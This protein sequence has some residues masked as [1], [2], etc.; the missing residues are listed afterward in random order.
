MHHVCVCVPVVA[1]TWLCR[2]LGLSPGYCFN[3]MH[4]T[5]GLFHRSEPPLLVQLLALLLIIVQ[6]G[7]EWAVGA[8]LDHLLV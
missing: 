3:S 2:P 4:L 5:D 6:G 1:Y 8:R 7:R